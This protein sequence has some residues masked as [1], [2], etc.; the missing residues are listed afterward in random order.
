NPEKYGVRL[1]K[2]PNKPYFVAVSTGKHMDIDIAAKL[3][4]ISVAEFKELNPAF[5]LPV[6]AYKA[7]R[8]M[9][10]PATKID[11]FQANLDKWDK[12]L[13][14]WE[15][16]LPKGDE[17]PAAIASQHGMSTSQLLA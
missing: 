17:S 8:Q 5:N 10:L 14:T 7:G 11:K 2:F 4:G 1:D 6:F 9:L 13:L 15:V 12:P 3:A 16:Y